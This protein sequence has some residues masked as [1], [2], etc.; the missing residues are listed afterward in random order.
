MGSNCGKPDQ[1]QRR[2]QET[3][4]AGEGGGVSEGCVYGELSSCLL[5]NFQMCKNHHCTALEDVSKTWSRDIPYYFL[6]F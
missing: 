1:Q 6:T 2:G 5:C 3:A 4:S